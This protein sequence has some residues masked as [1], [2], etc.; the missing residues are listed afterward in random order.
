L[1]VVPDTGPPVPPPELVE[2][3]EGVFAYIQPDGG[4]CLNNAG[5]VVGVREVLLVDTA[6]TE[7]RARSL[8]AAVESLDAGPVSFIV[9][10]H[11]H[12]DHTFGN[13]VFEPGATIV[14]HEGT[15]QE[16]EQTGLALTG[17][18]PDV[19]WGDVRPVLPAITYTDT[20][21]MRLKDHKVEL[22]HVG[23][24]HT[25]NDTVV[26]LPEERI[27]F[28]G[29]VVIPGCTP[30]T[31]MGTVSG[32]LVALD[33]LRALGARTIVGGHGPVA[34]PE[35][36]D[37]TEAYLRWIQRVAAD[38]ARTGLTPLATARQCDLGYFAE[39]HDP[40][41]IVGNL[42]RAFA[43]IEGAEPAV[44]LDVVGIFGEMIEYNG[45]KLPICHA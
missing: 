16:M 29:D 1:T 33:R 35:A 41:R 5:V 45:G 2:L 22:I 36:L 30:F 42:Y 39:L 44:T 24:A 11:F 25:R 8:C 13:G 32:S 23:P 15:R 20:L 43:E 31:L 14:G 19:E 10:T 27:L 18:W 7:R 6:A 17:L 28:A 40:E 4:W 3:A 38:G 21:T 12:G 26:W 9:N 37:E 34:G